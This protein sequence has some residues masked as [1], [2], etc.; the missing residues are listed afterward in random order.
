M[1]NTLKTSWSIQTAYRVNSILY[2]LKQVPGLKRFLPER[3]YQVRGLKIFATV[4]SLAWGFLRLFGG[5]AAYFLVFLSWP[6][7]FY[8]KLPVDQLYL[9]LLLIL[10]AIGTF[11]NTGFAEPSYQRYYA[12]SL[13]RMN[14]R[15]YTLTQFGWEMVKTVVGVLPFSLLF[16]WGNGVPQWFCLLF[17]FCVVGGKLFAVA[18]DLRA[19]ER[20]GGV[21]KENP[22]LQWGGAAVLLI[23]AYGLPLM[24]LVF[25]AWMSMALLLLMIPQGLVSLPAF[26]RFQ[27]YRQLNQQVLANFFSNTEAVSNS[28][29]K[30]T[31]NMISQGSAVSSDKKGFEYLNELFIK[32]HQKLLWRATW[33]ISAVCVVLVVAG[34]VLLQIFPDV[35]PAVREGILH[36]LP[37]WAF[38]LYFLSRGMGFTRALF[39]NCDHSLLTY[40]FYKQPRCVL[41][42]FRIR[43]REICKI[44]AVPA[45][46]LGLGLDVI[47]LVSGGTD[48]WI[49]Y[50]VVPATLISMSLF[51]AIHYLTLYYL[52]QPYNAGTEIKS[53]TY[54]IITGGTYFV[55]Y[56]LT[57]IQ[58]PVLLFGLLC[59]GFCLA[60]SVIACI[61]VYRIAPRT[62][63]IRQ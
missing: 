16:G 42:L 22:W 9:Q 15:S 43:L 11:L 12:V 56:L 32:R 29:Q 51:F 45:W 44:N 19:F 10:T 17:P 33:Q 7:G 5:K 52:L 40:S 62:F 53:G 8:P 14:A 46:I 6:L 31:H 27:S 28:V 63:R 25:P 50:L 49:E 35:Q 59:I 37:L 21:I 24:G 20:R 61:L 1:L 54:Q 34:V 39:I 3:L 18:K 26:R 48:A 38:I 47:L 60:Y 58:L 13:L 2:S 41:K 4:L 23:L 36:S 57:K 55:C 30:N